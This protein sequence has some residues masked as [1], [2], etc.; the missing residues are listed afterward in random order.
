MYQYVGTY[1][2]KYRSFYL[3]RKFIKYLWLEIM[4][5]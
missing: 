1:I 2:Y 3:L 4:K 5:G